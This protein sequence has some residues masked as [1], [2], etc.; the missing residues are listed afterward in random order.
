MS[1]IYR[2]TERDLFW[3][4]FRLGI[5]MKHAGLIELPRLRGW[6][7]GLAITLLMQGAICTAFGF[8]LGY[9]AFQIINNP[10]PIEQVSE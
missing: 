1:K 10:T 6:Q 3:S 8:Y 5:W 9:K 4:G 7:T 2:P